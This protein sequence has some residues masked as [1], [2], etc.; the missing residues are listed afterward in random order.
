MFEKAVLLI[1]KLLDAQAFYDLRASEHAIV[2]QIGRLSIKAALRLGY[3]GGYLAR[4]QVS[5]GEGGWRIYTMKK[6][7]SQI[8]QEIV[9]GITRRER[10][11]EK[12]ADGGKI[13][14]FKKEI[15]KAQILLRG[16]ESM[17]ARLPNP[18]GPRNDDELEFVNVYGDQQK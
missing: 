11:I 8:R 10:Y 2:S 7:L 13:A 6:T 14:R 5:D 15:E 9:D 3:N 1:V 18:G 17:M 16:C 12:L 4:Y